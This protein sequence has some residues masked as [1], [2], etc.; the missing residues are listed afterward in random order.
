M[1]GGRF[2][3][4]FHCAVSDKENG[5]QGNIGEIGNEPERSAFLLFGRLDPAVFQDAETPRSLFAV[6]VKPG[7]E[8]FL[9][10]ESSGSF[11]GL[12]RDGP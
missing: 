3:R 2:P 5:A 11:P 8:E 10:L 12:D 1:V 9:F 6:A 4:S 7:K